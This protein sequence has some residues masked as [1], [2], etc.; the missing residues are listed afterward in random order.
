M[1]KVNRNILNAVLV[2][3]GFVSSLLMINKNKV[4]TRKQTIPAFF[5]GNEPYILRIVVVWL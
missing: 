2:G 5:K 3:A 4:I 1:K